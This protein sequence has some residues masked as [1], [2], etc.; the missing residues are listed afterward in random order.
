MLPFLIPVAEA[1]AV[2]LGS[3][4]VVDKIAL[5]AI[6]ALGSFMGYEKTT[7]NL[8]NPF[9]SAP[10]GKNNVPV[11]FPIKR[12]VP[13]VSPSVTV[14]SFDVK[15]IAPVLSPSLYSYDDSLAR[16]TMTTQTLS[17]VLSLRGEAVKDRNDTLAQIAGA[18]KFL[19]NQVESK[20]SLDEISFAVNAQSLVHAMIYETL[21]RNLSLIATALTA[22]VQVANIGNNIASV[23]SVV[24][25]YSVHLEKMALTAV[26][27][28]VVHDHAQT[29]RDIHDL[30]G[31]VVARMAPMEAVATK[32]ITGARTSTDINSDDYSGDLPSFPDLFPVLNFSGRSPSF[33]PS[34]PEIVNPFIHKNLG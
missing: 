28:K 19:G 11:T 18:S 17:N 32:A 5:G 26:S 31:A 23:P 30:D 13:I 24:P 21:E 1:V 20:A 33:D 6:G 25:D 15:S 29:V 4:A 10:S 14:P 12:P 22:G 9:G 3:M 34:F 2:R 8:S 7:E 16:Q 27:A